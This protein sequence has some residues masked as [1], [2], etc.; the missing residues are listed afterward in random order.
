MCRSPN[1]AAGVRK[2]LVALNEIRASLGTPGGRAGV[3]IVGRPSSRRLV[4]SATT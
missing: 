4:M 1:G 3:V 2:S